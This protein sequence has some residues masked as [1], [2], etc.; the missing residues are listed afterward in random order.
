MFYERKHLV[1]SDYF[2]VIRDKNFSFQPHMHGCF[3]MIAAIRGSILVNIDNRE[4]S[5]TPGQ[6]VL[7]FPHQIHSFETEPGAVHLICIFSRCLSAPMQ[8]RLPTGIRNPISF[9]FP[10]PV[11]NRSIHFPRMITSTSSREHCTSSAEFSTVR[12]I[13]PTYR[14]QKI[15]S[16]SITSFLLLKNTIRKTARW[17]RCP[18]RSTT[19][20]RIFPD[21]SGRRSAY[22]FPHTSMTIAQAKSA[23]VWTIQGT[24]F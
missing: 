16:C 9:P 2:L 15:T 24:V 11:S 22:P 5:V 4:Y 14:R 23:A 6:A 17:K 13:T 8:N 7:V 20:I 3:E 1:G 21:I 19:A 18:A 12:R 10:E